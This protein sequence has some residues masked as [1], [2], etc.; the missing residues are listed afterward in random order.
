MAKR[1]LKWEECTEMWEFMAYLWEDVAIEIFDGTGGGSG[2][3]G[4]LIPDKDPWAYLEKKFPAPKLKKFLEIVVLVNGK[5]FRE[6]KEVEEQKKLVTVEHI[7]KV[8]DYYGLNKV[9]VTAELKDKK[10]I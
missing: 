10:T 3:G 5:R 7:K 9:K 1:F 6:V 8:F 4:T 2:E